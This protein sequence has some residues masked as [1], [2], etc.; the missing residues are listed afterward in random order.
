MV[1]GKSFLQKLLR[2]RNKTSEAN[3]ALEVAEDRRL[4]A[5]GINPD[6]HPAA[7]LVELDKRMDGLRKKGLLPKDK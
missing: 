5:L 7:I 1:I 3:A 2:K 4:V 6:N